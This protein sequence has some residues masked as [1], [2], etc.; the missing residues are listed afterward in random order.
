MLMNLFLYL[1][2]LGC[3]SDIRWTSP[4]KQLDI[5]VVVGYFKPQMKDLS[6]EHIWNEKKSKQNPWSIRISVEHSKKVVSWKG[7]EELVSRKEL[8]VALNIK[9]SSIKMNN[10]C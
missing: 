6:S 8:S 5:L 9:E 4:P 1:L 2:N 3:L 10:K 7:T